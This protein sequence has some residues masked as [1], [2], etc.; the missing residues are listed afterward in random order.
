MH[1]DS[2]AIDHEVWPKTGNIKICIF[3]FPFTN[4]SLIPRTRHEARLRRLLGQF[5]VVGL[6]GA[7]QVGK[8]TLA[9]TLAAHEPGRITFFDL[10]DPRDEARFADPVLALESLEGLVVIDEVQRSEEL[11][12]VLRVLVDRPSNRALFLVLGSA[13]PELLRQSSE[14]LAGRIAYH[15]LPPLR[16]DETGTEFADRLWVRG[17]FP[18]SFL[19]SGDAESAAWRTAFVRT[20]LER[21]LPQLG[22][23]VPAATMRRFWTMVAHYHGGR[24]NA[25][26][27]ARAMGVSAPTANTYLDT[28]V[29]SLLV[30][31][32][33]PWF[34]NLKKRQVKAPKIYL[35]DTGLLHTLLRLD[36][37]SALLGHPISGASWE[38]FAMQEAVRILSVSWEDCYYWATHRGAEIDLLV[39]KSGHRIGVEFKRNSAPRMT[40]SMHSALAD[41]KLDR[42]YVV[43]PGRQRFR[44]HE[45][46]EAVG[47]ASACADGLD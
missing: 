18:L 28:L 27:V 1:E 39:F 15:E 25:S 2:L 47:L 26:E 41:L 32:L 38:G 12:R 3:N 44:L 19:A 11:F 36:S 9:R 23:T 29:D 24:W 16:A 40:K 8:T 43:F 35:T 34:E 6:V 31:K 33:M 7:R 42:L 4:A 14:S 45:R 5:P 46:V 20:F 13:G 10:E 37:E 17:G 30:R 21:D 22:V